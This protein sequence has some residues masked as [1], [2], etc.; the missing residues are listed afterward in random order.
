VRK[1]ALLG[2]VSVLAVLLYGW[3]LVTSEGEPPTP[4]RRDDVRAIV[5]LSDGRGAGL[6]EEPSVYEEKVD[7]DGLPVIRKRPTTGGGKSEELAYEE[8]VELFIEDYRDAINEINPLVHTLLMDSRG[9]DQMTEAEVRNLAALLSKMGD[10]P[11]FGAIES[12]PEGYDD[13]SRHLEIGAISLS[14]AADSI[15]GFNR[16][17]DEEYLKDYQGLIGMY[18]QAVS[19]ARSCVVSQLYPA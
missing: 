10:A 13:C 18:L 15:R 4:A 1:L 3:N 17:S 11:K 14:L 8:S 16:T 6:D 12:Y 2:V 19:D 7:G 5:D 9:S